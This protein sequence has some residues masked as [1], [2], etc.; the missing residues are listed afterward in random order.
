MVQSKG[1]SE[2]EDSKNITYE[3]IVAPTK[4][5][6]SKKQ[7]DAVSAGP[8]IAIASQSPETVPSDTAVDVEE[9]SILPGAVQRVSDQLAM[10]R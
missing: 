10:E 8:V 2:S 1:T 4:T 6:R 7:R 3:E 9:A 5:R